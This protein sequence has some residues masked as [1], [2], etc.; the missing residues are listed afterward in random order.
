MNRMWGVLSLPNPQN[1]GKNWDLLL[2]QYQF[3]LHYV[4]H[5]VKSLHKGSKADKY[6]VQNLTLSGV[7]LGNSFSNNIIQ[8]V[9]TLVQLADTGHE[10]YVATM[11]TFLYN[12]YD[13]L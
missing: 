2:H 1:N 6:V 12:S 13:I 7:Y 9:L 8:K 5:H 10:V 3:T 11:P 4:K